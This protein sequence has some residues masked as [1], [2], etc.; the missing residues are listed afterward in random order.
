MD[1]LLDASATKVGDE[2]KV[3]STH[4]VAESKHTWLAGVLLPEKTSRH[5]VPSHPHALAS[6][7]QSASGSA[8]SKGP[9][10]VVAVLED[11]SHRHAVSC[12]IA[13]A[14]PLFTMKSETPSK[15][16]EDDDDEPRK[17]F[18]SFVNGEGAAVCDEPKFYVASDVAAS[19]VRAAAR[20]VD[21]PPEMMGTSQMV[22]EA[23]DVASRLKK[24]GAK[25]SCEVIRGKDLDKKGY[26]GI[27]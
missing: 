3:V 20:L 8:P 14:F 7:L 21:S 22:D 2:G 11:P 18:V 23:K 25:V 24:A 26:G 13:R 16:D 4:L 27:W 1:V 19:A 15:E 12:A 5:N 17:V 9:L 6:L 10:H